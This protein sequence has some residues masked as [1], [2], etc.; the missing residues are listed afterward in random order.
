MEGAFIPIHVLVK[1]LVLIFYEPTIKE[2]LVAR[3]KF[4]KFERFGNGEVSNAK[5]LFKYVKLI[6]IIM[7]I[8]VIIVVIMFWLRPYL[9]TGLRFI[10]PCWIYPDSVAL[11]AMVLACEY[12]TIGMSVL[13]VL[14]YDYLYFS[15]DNSKQIVTSAFYYLSI[16]IEFGYY[17]FPA[18]ILA[19]EF[20]KMS[21]AIYCSSWYEQDISVQ[22]LLLFMMVR[23]QRQRYMTAGGI[24]EINADSFSSILIK[25]LLLIFYKSTIKE[26]LDVRSKFWKF[27][28]FGNEATKAK[29]VFKYVKFVQNYLMMSMIF[30]IIMFWLRPYLE[31]NTR[32]I[33]PCWVYPDSV[34]L[35]AIVLACQYYALGT[36]IPIVL[37]YDYLYFSYVIHVA[38]QIRLLN[39][40]LRTLTVETTM[41]EL[42][43]CLQYHHFLLSLVDFRLCVVS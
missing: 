20:G 24:F 33:F 6:Q 3:S 40:K 1:Y 37:G 28:R 41:M 42:R 8:S 31:S 21:N 5:A 2:L 30:V 9:E 22:R 26:L 19:T 25:Y 18:D 34:V 36:A 27:E 10:F 38:L 29:A 13:I 7:L 15:N 43:E 11:E 17:A 35:E 32:T 16:L 12:Y 23:A 39:Y 14:G 4:W